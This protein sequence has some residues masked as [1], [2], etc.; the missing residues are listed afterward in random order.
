MV[1]VISE[2]FRIIG[3][4]ASVLRKSYRGR[5]PGPVM[6][7]VA[8]ALVVAACGPG[9]GALAG[10]KS[11][12]AATGTSTTTTPRVEHKLTTTTTAPRTT[13][14]TTVPAFSTTVSDVTATALGATWHTG[15]PVT[16]SQLRDI[17]M[18]YWGF[19]GAPH[20][21]TIV[22]NANVVT[23]VENVFSALYVA[24]FPLQEMVPESAYGGDDNA[25]AAADDT[26]GFNCRYVFAPGPP[27]WSKHAFGD[28]IDVNDV[29]NPYVDGTLIIPPAGA[30]YE[31]R[32]DVRPGMAVPG[33]TL[34]DAF[35]AVG[36][37]WGGRWTGTPDYQHFSLT[38]G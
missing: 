25:A 16:P 10:G 30:T 29:Q 13:T 23:T 12:R 5:G 22:V 19:D 38:G 6:V 7:L 3:V 9:G 8:L 31:N 15:C 1:A 36:W 11:S 18:S 21:G 33:G 14:T 26:S 27:Q 20:L 28:A 34:V 32:T 17:R 37:Q 4:C 24:R 35:A 2:F